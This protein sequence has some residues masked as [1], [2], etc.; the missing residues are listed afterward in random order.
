MT[1]EKY[2]IFK[3]FQNMFRNSVFDNLMQVKEALTAGFAQKETP[4]PLT[5]EELDELETYRD[6]EG[7][8]DFSKVKDRKN[9]LRLVEL[10]DRKN[11]I[12]EMNERKTQPVTL[13]EHI[14][15]LIDELLPIMGLHE[16]NLKVS[17]PAGTA[18]INVA[19]PW[20]FCNF[21]SIILNV[22]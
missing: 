5:Q 20:K 12:E 14:S 9:L 16:A 19:L 2:I 6:E 11:A 17:T 13:R 4:I 10:V 3:I 8:L 15:E 1:K 7:Y 21:I 18:S 22:F